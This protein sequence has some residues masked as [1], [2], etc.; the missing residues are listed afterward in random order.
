MLRERQVIPMLD[1]ALRVVA[2]SMS[3]SDEVWFKHANPWSGWTR[4]TTY[5]FLI[6]AFWSRDWLGIWFL[7]P[8]A[9]VLAWIWINPRVFPR[10][11]S[12]SNWMSKV[13]FGERIFTERKKKQTQIPKHHV[14]AA[15]IINAISAIGLAIL[16]YGLI[17]LE[18]WPTL[19]G[20]AIALLGK[21]W[22]VDRMAW[23]YED[24]KNIPEYGEWAY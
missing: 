20:A 21:L 8:V 19:S 15:N 12:T 9:V 2:K 16:I 3:L 7:I 17:V 13:V 22:F 6:L 23:L 11:K 18:I 14:T 10:P 5:P 4:F 24:M 1:R